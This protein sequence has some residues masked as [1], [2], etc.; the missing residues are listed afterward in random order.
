MDAIDPKRFE[1][2]LTSINNGNLFEDFTKSLLCQILGYEF[3]PMG[4]I[5][6]KGID[7]L[8]HIFTPNG[9]DR[10]IYQLSIQEN[11]KEKIGLTLEAFKKNSI[12]CN[13]L[14]YVTN[15]VV[16]NQHL[17]CDEFF[18]KYNV[19]VI[20]YDLNWLS[21]NVNK[22]AGSI[23]VYQAFVETYLHSVTK[24][25]ES[26][27]FAD[28]DTDPR[29]FVFLRQQWE[30]YGKNSKLNDVLADSLILYSLEGTDPEK[31]LLMSRDE[32]IGKITGVIKF[33]LKLIE[34]TIDQRLKI[35]SKNPQKINHH[36]KINKYCL[37]FETRFLLNERKL[38]DEKLQE[39]FT[40]SLKT[41]LEAQLSSYGVNVSDAEKL[42]VSAIN[43][44]FKQ[45]GLEFADFVLRAENKDAIEKSM[46]DVIE[47]SVNESKIPTDK[48]N[49]VKMSL[50]K[51][52]RDLI[53]E[54]SDEERE[55]L[56]RLSNTYMMLFLLRCDPQIAAYFSITASKLKVFV[57][58]SILVPALSE[59]NLEPKYRRHWNLLVRA[60]NAGV[61][62]FVNKV[63]IAELAGHLKKMLEVFKEKY[64]GSEDIYSEESEMIYVP[65]IIIRAY[66]YSKMRGKED[67]F[68]GF[69]NNFITPSAPTGIEEEIIE[70]LRSTFG[71]RFWEEK[72]S[73]V[74][75][76]HSDLQQLIENLKH[77]KPS[78]QQAKNDAQ[79]ILSIYALREKYNEKG[80]GGIFGYQT[81][82]LSKD[83]KTQIAVTECFGK[84]YPTSCYMRPDFLYNYISLAPNLD[85]VNNMFD[86]MFPTLM[87]VSISQY[88]VSK[89][90][91]D[92]IHKSVNEHKG[93]SPGRIRGVL[94]ILGDR[95][96]TDASFHN[97]VKL[98]HYL[99][100]GLN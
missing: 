38:I 99:D 50:L 14:F 43:N 73:E 64:E 75:I 33:S 55:Y 7:G 81:W 23:R 85:E 49:T 54:S 77:T 26:K 100:E 57:C 18:S 59:I 63:I 42:L 69:I 66:F 11:V 70:L 71:I 20:I 37:P 58:T 86:A 22:T 36:T 35:I 89:E 78:E 15:Q 51:V 41:R 21:G 96:K 74:H 39:K 48:R 62:L 31:N 68:A 46:P 98:K 65:E 17:L 6:D 53:Y 56:K 67:T 40:Q 27:L 97:V 13:R 92:A 25:E 88:V 32:I 12:N 30:S 52:V 2:V 76:E 28:L 9:I 83:T 3:I 19:S 82:W 5:K 4:G 29:I 45:Q 84:K 79:T 72:T 80:E 47:K 60:N 24:T 87:G 61:K 1:Y 93:M 91:A 44:L 34:P 10:T 95:L 8:E 94:R 90:M 16:K